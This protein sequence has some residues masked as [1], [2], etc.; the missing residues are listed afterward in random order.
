MKVKEFIKK[1]D[2]HADYEVFK[3]SEDYVTPN[4]SK[5]VAEDELHYNKAE[6]NAALTAKY[7]VAE[8]SEDTR[9]Y[10]PY[11]RNVS[12]IEVDG[13]EI[14]F[15]AISEDEGTYPLPAGEHTI[16]YT[17][18]DPTTTGYFIGCDMTEVILPK[19]LTEIHALAF[20]QAF[21][22]TKVN[23]PT[24]VTEIGWSAFTFT[25]LDNVV[26]PES[27]TTIHHNAFA[28][29]E[30]LKSINIPSGVTELESYVFYECK[31]LEELNIPSGVTSIG[32]RAFAGCQLLT[33]IEIPTGV[34][35]I[36]DMVFEGCKGITGV[37]LHSGITSIGKHAFHASGIV[38]VGGVGSG[39]AL[40]LPSSITKIPY[41]MFE[42][43]YDLKEAIIPEGI[44]EIEI[45]GFVLATGL[46]TVVL[47][48]TLEKIGMDAFQMA[49]SPNITINATVPPQL[50]NAEVF[51]NTNAKFY[52]PAESLEAYKTA[53][54][55]STYASK[56]YAQS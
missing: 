7:V 28:Y 20:R 15:S 24:G 3:A 10:Y 55:W 49:G 27:V 42:M 2:T 21:N 56:I 38:S 40:E 1:F 14:P 31:K 25:N 41:G 18:I 17:L 35:V 19:T 45:N 33:H 12:K 54:Y 50:Y 53:E 16:K 9:I 22:L 5:C 23:I 26:I 44:T 37:T 46:T 32:V 51:K 43:C 47:P 29:C 39:K 11:N 36:N 6:V 13:V 30:N 8:G 34:T 48:S 52:V 4:V